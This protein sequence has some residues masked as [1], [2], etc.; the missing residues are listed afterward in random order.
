LPASAAENAPSAMPEPIV[1]APVTEITAAPKAKSRPK[2]GQ[3]KPTAAPVPDAQAMSA[4]S[5][6]KSRQPKHAP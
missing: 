3:R 2:S 5:K 1:V 6:R 4:K